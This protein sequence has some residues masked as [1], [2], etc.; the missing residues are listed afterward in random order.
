[1]ISITNID[2]YPL[3]ELISTFA[4]GAL[5]EESCDTLAGFLED[6]F[7][8]GIELACLQLIVE[9]SRE[10]ETLEEVISHF[11]NEEEIADIKEECGEDES[12]FETVIREKIQDYYSCTILDT[13]EGY[14]VIE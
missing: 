3:S 14:L 8:D 6:T 7:S 11:F 2:K 1:M 10:F 12:N 5:T 9:Q 4:N 13:E